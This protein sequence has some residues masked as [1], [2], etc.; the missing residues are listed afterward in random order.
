MQKDPDPSPAFGPRFQDSRSR[1]YRM[2]YGAITAAVFGY[3]LWRT[4]YAGG[5]DWLQVFF[6]AIL[7]DLVAFI[8]IGVSSKRKE[9]PRWGPGLYN[10]SHTILLWG[11]LFVVALGVFGALYWPL[12]GWLGHITADRAMGFGLRRSID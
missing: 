9:W 10:L 7:P 11:L 5:V 12:L 4:F 1:L 3:L 8:P 2:E 6:F